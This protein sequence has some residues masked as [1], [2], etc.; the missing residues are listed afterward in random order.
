LEK[1]WKKIE[2]TEARDDPSLSLLCEMLDELLVLLVRTH[3]ADG[4]QLYPL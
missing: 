4:T 1:K 3:R 2:R